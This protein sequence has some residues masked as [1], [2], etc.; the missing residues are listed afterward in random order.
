MTMSPRDHRTDWPNGLSRRRGLT[1]VELVVVLVVLVA[2]AGLIVPLFGDLGSDSQEQATRATMA[3]VAEA[4]IGPGGY[5]EVM[6][7]ARNAADDAFVGSGTGLPW[8]SPTEITNGRSNHP[9][10]H[11][12][13][14]RPTDLKDYDDSADE[15]FYE[16]SLRIGWRDAWLSPTTATAY[17]ETG[18]FT[19]SY[20]EGD[21]ADGAGDDDLAPIDGWGNPIVIQLP[22]VSTGITEEEVDNVRLVSAGPDG[23]IDT[24]AGTLTPTVAQKNDDLVLY[25]YREDPNP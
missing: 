11:Y 17:A 10:L 7:L 6:R 4:I 3:Q 13:F 18:S 19:D 16:P 5:A 8:P 21:G 14:E 9:Q 1:L 12:L 20:G 23:V 24:P 15:Q 22:D 2:L 25:L